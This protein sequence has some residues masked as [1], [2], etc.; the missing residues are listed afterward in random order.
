M[1]H[2][3]HLS[4]TNLDFNNES[5]TFIVA[6]K[7][8]TMDLEDVVLMQSNEKL[9]LGK[10]DELKNSAELINTYFLKNFGIIFDN[11]SYRKAELKY[12]EKKNVDD[13]TWLYYEF[14]RPA[15]SKSMTI[16]T[17]LL[18]DLFPDQTNLVILKYLEK[19]DGAELNKDNKSYTFYFE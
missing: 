15:K 11:Q 1:T 13:S 9:N 12:K 2:P 19:N 7:F 16:N 5:G 18:F 10:Q 3:L 6:V 8:F 17:S 4:V 14:S